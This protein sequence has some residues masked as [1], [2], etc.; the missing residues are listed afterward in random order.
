MP[1]VPRIPRASAAV[2]VAAVSTEAGNSPCAVSKELHFIERAGPREESLVIE[3][4]VSLSTKVGILD[5]IREP[6]LP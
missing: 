1:T 4:D 5:P 3:A 2:R 6:N